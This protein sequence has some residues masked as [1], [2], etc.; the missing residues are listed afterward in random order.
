MKKNI[1]SK[2]IVLAI[3][4][5]IFFLSAIPSVNSNA[6]NKTDMNSN[7][8]FRFYSKTIKFSSPKL[9]DSKD[10]IKIIV[11]EASY[12][13]Q[14]TGKPMLPYTTF[15]LTFPL[16]TNI[17]NIE[18]SYSNPKQIQLDK[19]VKLAPSLNW[20]QTRNTP[21]DKLITLTNTNFELPWYSYQLGGGIDKGEHVT[22]LSFHVYPVNYDSEN[23][24]IEYIN[25]VD[26]DVKYKTSQLL[27][28]EDIYSLVII[29][30][31]NFIPPLQK[32]ADHKVE[33]G[34]TTK[35][36]SVDHIFNG[37]YFPAEGYD[38]PE[39]IK[40]FI[41]NA[42]EQWGTDYILLIGS[43]YNLPMRIAPFGNMKLLTDL[44]YADLYFGDGSFCDWDSNGNHIYGEYWYNDEKDIVDLYSDIYLGRIPCKNILDVKIAV[45]K[46][47]KYESKPI[48]PHDDWWDKIIL[49]GGDT[50]PGW[51]VYE[52]EVTNNCIAEALPEF[53]H[54]KLWTSEGTFT[55]EKINEEV[56][57]GARFLE[58]SGHGYEFGMGTSP[59]NDQNRINY[60]TY[61]LLG[62]DNSHRLPVVFFDACLTAKLDFVLG[63]LLGLYGFLNIPLPVY[64][65]YWMKKIG[66][67]AIATIG[68]TE[69][70]FSFVDG[71]GPNGGAGYLSL[72]FFEG[73]DNCKTVSE[74][75]VYSQNDYLNNLWKDHWTIEQFTLLGD[76]TLKVGGISE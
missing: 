33:N 20:Y 6:N 36:V 52:G 9:E 73:Y 75:L 30:P 59:P 51:G 60:Y 23:L 57:K 47:I 67:G 15:V 38:E 25:Q 2:M 16:G 5:L 34:L 69:I 74:M 3:I 49:L 50:F 68:A 29:S 28:Q 71:N 70:A 37:E 12:Y 35:L 26:I 56:S 46:I 8:D 18:I 17:E 63:D 31:S 27:F 62:L 10:S 21:N 65:W 66:G 42:V 41:K 11:D 64:A 13:T 44:Y 14:S 54:V 19:P 53:E 58:Y 40:Y 48:M 7:P 72:H 43:I 76:P 55:P 22:F 32:L 39:K 24:V 61:N 1:Y 4:I 45:N